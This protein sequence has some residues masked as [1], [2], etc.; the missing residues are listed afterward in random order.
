MPT[1]SRD[2]CISL[3]RD[4][5]AI[6]SVNPS[7]VPGGAGEG[8][9]AAAIAA[10]LRRLG[11]DVTLQEAAPGRP[12][13]IGVLDG[14]APGPSLMLCGHIDTVGVD[15]M[16][17]PFEPHER[18]GRLFGRGSQ[19][20]KGGVAAMIDA[21]RVV[22][23]RGLPRGRLIVAAVV[24]E[25][26]A[27]IG[28]DVLVTQWSADMAVV[29]EPTDLQIAV[30]HKGFAWIDVV[31]HGRAAHGSRPREGR[32]AIVRMGRVLG[33]LEALD[34]ELQSRPPH[35]LMGTGSLHASIVSGGRELSSY[36]DRCALQYERRTIV[37]EDGPQAEREIQDILRALRADD[38]E[39]AADATLTFSRPPYE[40]PQGHPLPAALAA[41]TPNRTAGV[42]GMSFW[43]DAAVLGHAGIPT[44]LFGPG[45]AG[46]HSTEEYVNLDDVVAC[47][48]ALAELTLRIGDLVSR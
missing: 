9:I 31:T 44:V 45:G 8:A 7:L 24:D 37:G 12:N 29:T 6:D 40:L 19:D 34:R 33:R 48:D 22:A 13:V 28:A 43:T 4:L 25:E 14:R 39:F 21:A 38:A 41:S 46:L 32:D 10:H 2:P 17:N 36:P 3:L 42:V 11:V 30:G 27:S 18:D 1:P 15:G 35:P 16:R 26:Y 47:R 23:E 20:M 5:V